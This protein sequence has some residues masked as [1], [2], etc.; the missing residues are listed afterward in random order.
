[1]L[2]F[3]YDSQHS[4][5]VM[6]FLPWKQSL[7]CNT[8]NPEELFWFFE[9][10]LGRV[11]LMLNRWVLSRSKYKVYPIPV[12]LHRNNYSF[13]RLFSRKKCWNF[14]SL[15]SPLQCCRSR[16]STLL[17]FLTEAW[18]Q[19]ECFGLLLPLI[20]AWCCGLRSS[21]DLYIFSSLFAKLYCS[22]FF[23]FLLIPLCFF[24]I[25]PK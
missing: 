11:W 9:H 19:A 1:M 6:S 18:T 25:V 13:L 3:R 16:Q 14:T 7:G 4:L 22:P 23:L 24:E 20:P 17:C 5:L 21:R 15:H 8:S 2:C 12:C 10:I